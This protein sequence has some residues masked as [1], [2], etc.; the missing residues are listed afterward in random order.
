MFYACF[1]K[2]HQH[3]LFI[4]ELILPINIMNTRLD[5]LPILFDSLNL[6]QLN[7]RQIAMISQ[8]DVLL[9]QTQC[10]LCGH[11]DGCLPYACGIVMQGERHNLCVPGGQPV[12]DAI[13]QVLSSHDVDTANLTA[14]ASKWQTDP[15]THRPIEMRAV[16][17]EDECIGC[18]KCIPACP[19]DAII[20]T[21]KHMHSIITEL[22]T[23]CELCLPPCPVDCIQL[24]PHEQTPDDSERIKNQNHLRRRYHQHLNRVASNISAGI[25]PVVSTVE[26]TISNAINQESNTHINESV[27]KNTI[28]MAKIRTQI[29]KLTKQLA[30]RDDAALTTKLT[31]LQDKLSLL[32]NTP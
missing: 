8:I 28:E 24:V 14:T 32:E 7:D 31:Q 30:I 12:T 2:K 17:D 20:G 26:A 21:A 10:G 27:A 25:K 15:N 4:N 5:N 1:I 9:P 23:G 29:K 18:T 3:A 16:I 11:P 6:S 13:H 22:C 19:V